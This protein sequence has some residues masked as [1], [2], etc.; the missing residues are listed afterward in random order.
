MLKKFIFGISV[1][2]V[3]VATGLTQAK[4]MS[5]DVI[6]RM[7]NFEVKQKCVSSEMAACLGVSQEDCKKQLDV[8]IGQCK[9]DVPKE[10]DE[11]N[12]EKVIKKYG[13]CVNEK[14]AGGIK[15]PQSKVKECETKVGS[16]FLGLG[17]T[18]QADRPD[19][20]S[21]T[22]Q[23]KKEYMQAQATKMA[24]AMQAQ[25]KQIGT[26]SVTL[27][28]YKNATAVSHF[29]DDNNITQIF[30]EN[31][32]PS[33]TLA[34]PDSV[35]NIADFYKKK[36]KGFTQYELKQGILFLE[37]GPKKFDMNTDMAIFVTSPH[38][39]IAAVHNDTMV[40]SGSKSKIEIAYK[41]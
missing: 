13:N 2:S 6:L 10:I 24:A 40:P 36:L 20:S 41:K 23:E 18:G 38:V 27:P 5:T 7:V 9:S 16:A 37:N 17:L 29:T 14:L 34:S 30:N 26:K 22:P 1:F 28:I 21:M 11:N 3:V 39:W 8:A 35:E 31:A 19:I 15:I 33:L 4:E 25:A 32:L 12:G